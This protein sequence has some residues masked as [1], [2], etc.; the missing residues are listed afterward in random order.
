ME[1]HLL[2]NKWMNTTTEKESCRSNEQ[3]R[4][5]QSGSQS[6]GAN[7][8]NSRNQ[9]K[10]HHHRPGWIAKQQPELPL[11]VASPRAHQAVIQHLHA[12][13]Q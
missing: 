4:N 1:E 3:W 7:R 13:R 6:Y 10:E 9:F 2:L 5:S 8:S 12:F 11:T